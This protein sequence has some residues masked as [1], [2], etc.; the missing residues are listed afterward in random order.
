MHPLRI[1]VIIAG[2]YLAYT[3]Y[4]KQTVV[5][6]PDTNDDEVILVYG[7]QEFPPQPTDSQ[8]V[9]ILSKLDSIVTDPNDAFIFANAFQQ[10]ATH[11]KGDH[12]L[13]NLNQ[14]SEVYKF[15]VKDLLT[16]Q[17]KIPGKYGGKVDEVI[18][19]LYKH[20]LA[21][22]DTGEGISSLDVTPQ[23]REALVDWMNGLS[24]KFG[25]IFLENMEVQ[26]VSK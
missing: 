6:V 10:W 14:V 25:Q 7:E 2:L 20:E 11:I 22:L 16:I 13:E 19:E 17:G 26:N 18:Q 1:L 5:P 8:S 4:N 21:F 9:A 12:N 23:V 3:G 24:W 15:A